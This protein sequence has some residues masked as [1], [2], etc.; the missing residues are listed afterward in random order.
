MMGWFGQD[1][2]PAIDQEDPGDEQALRGVLAR[3]RR[4]EVVAQRLVNEQLG[5]RYHSIFKGRGMSFDEVRPYA[6]GDEVRLIDWNVSAR[7]GQLHVKRFVEE[8]ELTVML[9]ADASLSMDFG[10]SAARW[11]GRE[12]IQIAEDRKRE[13]AAQIAAAVALSAQI[14]GDRVGLLVFGDQV[15]RFIPPKKG[16]RHALRVI[17]EVLTMR[18]GGSPTDLA[19]ALS[20]LGRVLKRRAALFLISDFH[21][22]DFERELRVAVR[23]HDVHAFLVRDPVE[24]DLPEAGLV[25]LRDLESGERVVVPTD[26]KTRERYRQL[27]RAEEDRCRQVWDRYRVPWTRFSTDESYERALTRH[28][29]RLKG[30]TL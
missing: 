16:R 15:V 19:G 6:P 14:N 4:I 7:T 30:K 20:Y 8:R 12:G 1:R 10:L 17:R 28:F 2:R 21:V 13:V 9:V 25:T 3:V 11:S 26:R 29:A 27:V 24:G 5:G 22:G 18:H 23:R